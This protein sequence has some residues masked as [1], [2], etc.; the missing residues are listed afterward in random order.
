MFGFILENIKKIKYNQISL[1][2]YIF[3]NF[4]VHIYRRETNKISLNK[5][6]DFFFKEKIILLIQICNRL[7]NS[8]YKL[9]KIIKD[10]TFSKLIA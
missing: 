3:L 9:L 6:I 5:H 4:L 8:R 7:M 2:F 10:E 1:I